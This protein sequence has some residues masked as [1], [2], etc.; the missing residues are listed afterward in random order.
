[1]TK[2]EEYHKTYFYVFVEMAQPLKT[3]LQKAWIAS[4]LLHDGSVF[5]NSLSRGLCSLLFSEDTR[6]SWGAH[7][8]MEDKHAY[9]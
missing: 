6:Y 9:T 2:D 7:S 4:E 5:C 8:Y 1:M 3:L